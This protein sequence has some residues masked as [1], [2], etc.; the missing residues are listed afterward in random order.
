MPGKGENAASTPFE[1][2]WGMFAFVKRRQRRTILEKGWSFAFGFLFPAHQ[3]R[4]S[5]RGGTNSLALTRRMIS[6]FSAVAPL[7]SPPIPMGWPSLVEKSFP[8]QLRA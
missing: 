6:P 8:I 1:T 2:L 3:S 5:K 7:G 4:I